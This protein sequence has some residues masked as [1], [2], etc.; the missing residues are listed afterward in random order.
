[1]KLY[2]IAAAVVLALLLILWLAMSAGGRARQDAARSKA[3]LVIA[4]GG[5]RAATD[6]TTVVID[7]N[8]AENASADL[9][10][11]NDAEIRKAPGA[12]AALQPGLDLAGR[13]ALC[14]RRAY[15]DQP[16]CKQLLNAR[17]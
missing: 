1:M 9:T 4:Q 6:A 16:A 8:A 12:A 10:R 15:I 17:P 3:G 14:L 13:R 5:T 2:T 7:Q 11:K